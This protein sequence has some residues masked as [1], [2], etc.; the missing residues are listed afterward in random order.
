MY[1]KIFTAAAW[2]IL[3]FIVFVTLSPIGLRPHFE[4]VSVERFG[5]FAV[6]GLLFGLAYPKRLWLVLCLV[7]GTAVALEALQHL[8]PDRHGHVSDAIVKI[9]GG[10]AG[11]GAAWLAIRALAVF[12]SSRTLP[13]DR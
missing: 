6:V 12:A 11:V 2:A 8:T 7:A 1:Q 4:N 9:V 3:A 10:V 5:A 13:Q